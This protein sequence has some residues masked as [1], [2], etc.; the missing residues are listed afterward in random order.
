MFQIL[1][2]SKSAGVREI[3]EQYRKLVMKWHP[4]KQKDHA[5][6]KKAHEIFIKIQNA[7]ETL[8][9]RPTPKT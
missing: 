1:G 3:K 5:L 8:K 4:D 9:K 2:V 7:Y 6:K